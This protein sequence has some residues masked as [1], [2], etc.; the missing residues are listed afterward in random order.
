MN[1][2][3]NEKVLKNAHLYTLERQRFGSIY[4]RR[5]T[6]YRKLSII[7]V[8]LCLMETPAFNGYVQRIM[9]R[10][11]T[12]IFKCYLLCLGKRQFL[13]DMFRNL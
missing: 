4:S 12:D 6:K 7:D 5:G 9:W 13:T 8:L 11:R 1:L 3:E 2:L 10:A